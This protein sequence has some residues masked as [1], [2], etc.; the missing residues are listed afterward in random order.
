MFCRSHCPQP[1]LKQGN[2]HRRAD[3]AYRRAYIL[4][5]TLLQTIF[6]VYKHVNWSDYANGYSILKSAIGQKGDQRPL[7]SQIHDVKCRSDADTGRHLVVTEHGYVYLHCRAV[8]NAAR[9]CR[10]SPVMIPTHKHTRICFIRKG[11]I[12]SVIFY[13]GNG[14][15]NVW[16][17]CIYCDELSIKT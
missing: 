11:T 5:A 7:G 8:C 4:E 3:V 1:G 12:I 2:A 16:Y 10:G 15:I 17:G 13:I 14:N 9:L 6:L